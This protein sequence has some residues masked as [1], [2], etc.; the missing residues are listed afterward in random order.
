MER[1]PRSYRFNES[2]ILEIQELT[3]ILGTSE[4]EAVARAIHFYLTFLRNEEDVLKQR[5]VVPLAE[6]QAMQE[7]YNSQISQL[8]Y[9]VGELEGKNTEKEQTIQT[10]KETISKLIEAQQQKQNKDKENL[11]WKIFWWAT[12]KEE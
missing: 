5:S 7:K 12:R 4:T 6:Y 10:L 9:K 8:L 2:I 1:K 3:T 11:I